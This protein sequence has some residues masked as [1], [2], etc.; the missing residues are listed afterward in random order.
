[1]RTHSA[2]ITPDS[3]QTESG[4]RTEDKEKKTRRRLQNDRIHTQ[5]SRSLCV[6]HPLFF[7]LFSSL[8][9]LPSLSLSLCLSLSLS[10]YL[11]LYLAHV[12]CLMVA[13]FVAPSVR[14]TG[15]Q[16]LSVLLLWVARAPGVGGSVVLCL[17]C[18]ALRDREH[19]D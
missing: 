16:N 5:H 14:E 19:G 15:G 1:M 13:C 7:F 11:Y 10:I 17:G 9:L 6:S 3:R 8:F 4:E 2:Q 12:R 18:C